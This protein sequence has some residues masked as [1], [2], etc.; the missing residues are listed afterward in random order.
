MATTRASPR[1]WVPSHVQRST[2]KWQEEEIRPRNHHR[3]ARGKR[4]QDAGNL[5]FRDRIARCGGGLPVELAH[6]SPS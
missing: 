5:A 1:T 2:T 6:E 4:F 3:Q